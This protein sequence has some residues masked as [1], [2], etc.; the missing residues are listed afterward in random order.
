MV[1]GVVV[2]SGHSRERLA[3]MVEIVHLRDLWL[4]AAVVADR[5]E[6]QQ[7][8]NRQVVMEAAAAVVDMGRMAA[9]R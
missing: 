2:G 7:V 6:M 9:A 4:S 8:S 3:E 1:K 5:M